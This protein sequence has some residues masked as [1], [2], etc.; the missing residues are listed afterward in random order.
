MHIPGGLLSDPVCAPTTVASSTALGLGFRNARRGDVGRRPIAGRGRRLVFAAQMVNFPVDHGTSGHLIGGALATALLGPWGAMWAM[1]SVVATQAIL[2]GDGG[3]A[4]LGANLL[5]MA[6]AAPWTAWLAYRG[7][8]NCGLTDANRRPRPVLA[9]RRWLGVWPRWCRCWRRRRFA[10]WCWPGAVPPRRAVLPAM[11][12]AHLPVGLVEGVATAAVVLLAAGRIALPLATCM[13]LRAGCRPAGW[14]ACCSPWRRRWRCCWPRWRRAHRT[15]W[16]PWRRDSGFLQPEAGG[17]AGLLPD[18][19]LPGIGWAPL[20]VALAGLVAWR[21]CRR[22][23][24]W[25]AGRRRAGA[26]RVRLAHAYRPAAKNRPFR[27]QVGPNQIFH[28]TLFNSRSNQVMS[29]FRS[30]ALC[31]IAIFLILAGSVLAA[32]RAGRA[33]CSAD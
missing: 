4:A 8:A 11:L 18:Y 10:R 33:I 16:K 17:F 27:A 3:I 21:P 15:G 30:C 32:D 31:L 28:R 7:L 29:T 19:A 24:I 20:A 26:N 22:P 5:T 25:L 9:A 14:A 12:L 6:V 2:F 1:A 23:A 13:R